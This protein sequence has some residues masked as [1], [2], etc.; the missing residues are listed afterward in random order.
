MKDK[1]WVLLCFL[2]LFG[3]IIA[4]LVGLAIGT[5]IEAV[6][7]P[8]PIEE[9]GYRIIELLDEDNEQVALNGE[10]EVKFNREQLAIEETLEYS[11]LTVGEKYRIKIN[12]VDED[13]VIVNCC[14]TEF[15]P[16]KSA[17]KVEIIFKVKR[18]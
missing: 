14:E 5:G 6:F 3:G 12:T 18:K 8:K 7:W 9:A 1:N 13:G 16:E 10:Y 2:I 4:G 17:G 11:S 15:T